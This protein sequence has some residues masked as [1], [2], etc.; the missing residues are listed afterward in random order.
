MK[1]RLAN[2]HDLSFIIKYDNLV[3]NHKEL[4]KEDKYYVI[5][6]NR[7]LIGFLR[8]NLFWDHIP[9][10]NLF[11]IEEDKRKSGYGTNLLNYFINEMLKNNYQVIMTSSQ[12]KEEGKYFFLKNNFNIVGGFNPYNEDYEL[13]LE[14]R[15]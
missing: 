12:S 13:I 5:E 6:E 7:E 9:F 11:Y 10:I 2:K 8:Y 3:L 4:I 14:R 15:L 1:I